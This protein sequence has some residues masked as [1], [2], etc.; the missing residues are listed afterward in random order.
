MKKNINENQT[1]F[2][3]SLLALTMVFSVSYSWK[4]LLIQ[5]Y[6]MQKSQTYYDCASDKLDQGQDISECNSLN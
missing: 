2:A 1:L 6:E 3:L 5:H 4:T